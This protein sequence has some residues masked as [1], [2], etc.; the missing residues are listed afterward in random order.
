MVHDARAAGS[1]AVE[2]L[3]VGNQLLQA[4]LDDRHIRS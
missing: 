1:C 3:R 2:Q 4:G